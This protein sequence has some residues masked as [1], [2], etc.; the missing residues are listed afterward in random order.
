MVS[1]RDTQPQVQA[2]PL[3][4]P[5]FPSERLPKRTVHPPSHPAVD[6]DADTDVEAYDVSNSASEEDDV[7]EIQEVV[8]KPPVLVSPKRQHSVGPILN[9][10]AVATASNDGV[11]YDLLPS[12]YDCVLPS[13]V[14]CFITQ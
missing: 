6:T 4:K 3:P 11:E 7:M 9:P 1:H 10:F 8:S 14:S 5:R 2:V 13:L 12:R